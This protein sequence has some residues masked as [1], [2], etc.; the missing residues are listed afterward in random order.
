MH[1]N[2]KLHGVKGIMIKKEE[3]SR[4]AYLKNEFEDF[5]SRTARYKY[6]G[7]FGVGRLAER[8]GYEFV[9]EWVSGKIVCFSD[10]N[11]GMWGKTIVDGLKCIP[12]AELEKYGKDFICVILVSGPAQDEIAN[13][14]NERGIDAIKVKLDWVFTDE[15]IEK[16]LEI[17][18]PAIWEGSAE[19]GHYNRLVNR[20][21]RIAVF[22]CIVNGY[23]DLRQPLVVDPQCDYYCLSL[24]EPDRPGIYR[25]ID[26]SHKIPEYLK[27]DFTR[28]NRYCKLHPH[29][30]FPQYNY[31]VYIDGK[32]VILTEIAHLL[33]RI[34]KIGIASYGMP[35][36]EDIYEHAVSIYLRNGLGEENGREK[37]KSQMKRYVEEGFPR[38]FGLTENGV[39]VRQHNDKN[40]IRVMETWWN[41]I[42]HNSR[43]DQ[44]SF[45]YALWK[46]GFS[47]SDIGYIDDT[48]RKGPEFHVLPSHNKDYL[49]SNVFNRGS[50]LQV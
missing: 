2:Q 45:M 4:I 44:L 41:E 17:K 3:E 43:R 39:M 47:L 20:R 40:C 12:P 15:L 6:V 21:E 32:I 13:Q 33:C 29:L 25:W 5:K 11:S 16:Y 23:D 1:A 34:G 10:N 27:S 37:I 35:F 8:W 36:A 24:E 19:M 28:I 46:N 22:T 30:F 38:F 50:V 14:L 48:F 9:R 26:I 31:S 49:C 18:L 42:L 7:L